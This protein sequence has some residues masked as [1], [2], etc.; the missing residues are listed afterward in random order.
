MYQCEKAIADLGD[1]L[2]SNDKSEIEAKI[3][4]LK[5]ALEGTNTE[6]IKAKTDELQQKFYEVSTKMYQAANPQGTGPDMNGG[7][8]MG[9]SNGG[10]YDGD[11]TVVD[12]D[13][14]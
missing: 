10:T 9:G 5:K 2:D 7:P 14:K 8:D 11:Y 6:D 1:K 13:N 3:A 12:D 4:E